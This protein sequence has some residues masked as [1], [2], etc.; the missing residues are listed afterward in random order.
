MESCVPTKTLAILA[1]LLLVAVVLTSLYSLSIPDRERDSERVK[2][3]RAL[4]DVAIALEQFQ[5]KYGR[6]PS[7]EAGLQP[8]YDTELLPNEFRA[9]WGTALFY[10]GKEDADPPYTVCSRRPENEGVDLVCFPHPSP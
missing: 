6:Y 8:L 10:F 2:T 5:R 9:A 7:Q 1:T 4:A 3:Y